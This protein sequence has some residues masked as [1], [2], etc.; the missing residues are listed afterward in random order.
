MTN[1][2]SNEQKLYLDDLVSKR[3]EE[4]GE[5]KETAREAVREW[6]LHGLIPYVLKHR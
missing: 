4:F 5:D 1:E 2:L 6:I 3:M